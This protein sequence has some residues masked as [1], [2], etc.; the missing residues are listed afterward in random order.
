MEWTWADKIRRNK[1]EALKK[2]LQRKS[3]QGTDGMSRT[4]LEAL[5]RVQQ[6]V[7]ARQGGKAVGSS[8]SSLSASTIS[9]GRPKKKGRKAVRGNG[10][11]RSGGVG[12][13][14]KRSSVLDRLNRSLAGKE[15]RRPAPKH[16]KQQRNGQ[17]QNGKRQQK[18]PM[19]KQRRKGSG[20]WSTAAS[21]GV[22]KVDKVRTK[23]KGSS[24]LFSKLNM[25]LD[26]LAALGN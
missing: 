3:E 15:Y 18:F 7:K 26:E 8:S 16:P 4:Q 5:S 13:A 19:G 10:V 21:A 14:K 20:S 11:G 6:E 25:S 22:R 1:E 24:D 17:R 9:Q 12:K 23:K 2:Y